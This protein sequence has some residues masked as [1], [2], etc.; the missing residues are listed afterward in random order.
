MMMTMMLMMMMMMLFA[1]LKQLHND[2]VGDD[3]V[4]VV[5]DGDK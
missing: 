4:D 2:V 5:V 3:D 1:V